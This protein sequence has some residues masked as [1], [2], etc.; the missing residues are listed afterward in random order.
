MGAEPRIAL[1][2]PVEPSRHGDGTVPPR[3]AIDG[4]ETGY[5]GSASASMLPACR[6]PTARI[7]VPA[8]CWASEADK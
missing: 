2:G 8:T 1:Y 5:C 3:A 7:R 4:R 6:W